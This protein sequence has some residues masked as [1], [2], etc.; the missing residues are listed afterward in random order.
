VTIHKSQ[1]SEYP[2][3]RARRACGKRHRQMSSP[4]ADVWQARRN[5]VGRPRSR[6]WTRAPPPEPRRGQL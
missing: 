1:D 6:V 2:A 3:V 5:R 4:G